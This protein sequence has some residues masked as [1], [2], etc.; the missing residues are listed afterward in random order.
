MAL[1]K[2]GLGLALFLIV[3]SAACGG[4]GTDPTNMLNNGGF[5]YGM[6][7]YGRWMWSNTGQEYRGDYTFALSTDAHSGSYALEIACHGGDCLK[8]AVWSY[9]IAVEA[10]RRYALSLFSKCPPAS[11]A[12][13]YIAD[14]SPEIFHDLKCTGGWE[15]NQL[16]LRV[17]SSNS[18]IS[19]AIYNADVHDLTLDDITLTLSNGSVPRQTILHSGTRSVSLRDGAVNVDGSPY[20]ALGFFDVPFADLAA[21]AATGAN[22]LTSLSYDTTDCFNTYRPKY[23]DA[24]HE[25]GLSVVPE[26][27]AA[28]HTVGVVAPMDA[29]V[30]RFGNHRSQIAWYLADEPDQVEVPWI[31]IDAQRLHSEYALAKTKTRLPIFS[32][33]RGASR[34]AVTA[35][36]SFAESTDFWMAEPY[37]WDFDAV[38]RAIRTFNAL[39][40]RPIWLAQDVIA[41]NLILPKAYW[42][43]AAGATGLLYF[44]WTEAKADSQRLQAVQQVFRELATLTPVIYSPPA[45]ATVSNSGVHILTRTVN[46]KTYLIAASADAISGSVVFSVPGLSSGTTVTVLF[47][48]RTLQSDSDGF[49]DIFPAATRHVYAF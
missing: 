24:A 10:G 30:D 46:G 1:T 19:I 18:E 27:N 40:A 6:M 42:A 38:D 41:A 9:P 13:V 43:V 45:P 25:L 12:Y 29:V 32:D 14:A 3:S 47:E 17:G 34:S 26:A 15:D 20:L 36:T 44:N 4:H 33:F 21:A 39:G 2:V 48:S 5:E 49:T 7:C 37:G 31:A 35:L 11:H 22:T 8:A 16:T 23:P 28:A